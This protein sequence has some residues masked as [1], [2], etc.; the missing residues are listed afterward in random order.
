[1]TKQAAVLACGIVMLATFSGLSV[2]DARANS[3][4]FV[5]LMLVAAGAYLAALV[6]VSRGA[7]SKRALFVCVLLSVASRG[8]LVTAAPV[9]SDDLYRYL[10]DGRIQRYGISPY[11]TTPNDADVRHLHT[12]L[13]N[14]IDPTSAALPTIYPP[15]A[16]LFFRLVTTTHESTTA[17]VVA[18]VLCDLLTIVVL[19]QWLV[20]TGREPWWVLVYAWN[21]VVILE[22]AGGGHID[23]VG[24]LLVV[25]TV[26]A[27][28][29]R[30]SLFAALNWS[31]A[32]TI[33]FLPVVLLP[34]LWRRLRL[35]DW[36]AAASLAGLVYLP[37]VFQGK[38]L[39]VGSLRPYAERWRFNGPIF[40]WL[41]PVM[42]PFGVLGI[43]TACGLFVAWRLRQ[44]HP[45]ESPQAWAWPMGTA[46]VF[47]PA[48]Y[49]W[50]LVWLTPFLTVRANWPLLGWTLTSVLTYLVWASQ[51]RDAGWVLPG[52]VVPVE[53]G[54]VAAIAFAVWRSVGNTTRPRTS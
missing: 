7:V 22:G 2:F 47:L 50:Y 44:T 3:G 35:R 4:A 11:H 36:V 34:L 49:P 16:Q 18:V 24:T 31:L 42:G 23:L 32:V 46:L 41:E 38:G 54:I 15:A 8:V 10:W 29:R 51:Q 27:L 6:L 30:W 52:W 45:M 39:P 40:E 17:I 26:Y 9:V 25:T 20:S 5:G 53:Y 14:Q 21:P 19:W 28:Q 37:F 1:M 12:D 33:K 13:T 48:I 43:A